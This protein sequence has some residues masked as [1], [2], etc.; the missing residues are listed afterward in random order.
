M[1]CP[2]CHDIDL[3]RAKSQS[4][5]VLVD[6]CPQCRGMWCDRGELERMLDVIVDRL[7]VRPD[8]RPSIRKCPRCLQR[9]RVIS[10]RGTHVTVDA[11]PECAG[12]W[13]DRGELQ[14]IRER[15]QLVHR[16]TQRSKYARRGCPMPVSE[17]PGVS[18][19]ADDTAPVPQRHRRP[20]AGRCRCMVAD[21]MDFIVAALKILL[22]A[23]YVLLR[24]RLR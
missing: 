20:Q 14:R 4:T 19:H 11:C 13:L 3:L 18:T 22:H 5:G 15:R 9:L 2:K 16:D 6:H 23:L 12:I 8:A 17:M 21:I 10:Y 1:Q 24:L 7:N